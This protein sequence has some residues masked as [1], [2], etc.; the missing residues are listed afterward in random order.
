MQTLS[1]ANVDL[2]LRIINGLGSESIVRINTGGYLTLANIGV[3]LKLVALK[4]HTLSI[5]VFNANTRQFIFRVSVA[6]RH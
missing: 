5:K 4:V 1:V 3:K 6:M 2:C